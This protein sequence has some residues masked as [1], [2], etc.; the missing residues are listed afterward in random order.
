MITM[1]LCKRLLQ[2]VLLLPIFI[3][4]ESKLLASDDLLIFT[5]YT[6]KKLG[7]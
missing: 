2:L 4:L 3:Q 1:Q 5:D 7:V 6:L